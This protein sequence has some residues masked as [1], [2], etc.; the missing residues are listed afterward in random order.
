MGQVRCSSNGNYG[1]CLYTV[2]KIF[3]VATGENLL[4]KKFLLKHEF[5]NDVKLLVKFIA[6]AHLCALNI[7]QKFILDDFL[8]YFL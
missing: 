8:V 7:F 5:H 2:N 6:I 4:I 1:V 3:I